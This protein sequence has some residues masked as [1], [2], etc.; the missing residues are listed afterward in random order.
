MITARRA[1]VQMPSRP[2]GPQIA[3]VTPREAWMLTNRVSPEG[4]NVAPANSSP[5]RS[6]SAVGC[7]ASW[8]RATSSSCAVR[9]ETAD[10]VS[11]G[12]SSQIRMAPR[13]L[14]DVMLSGQLEVGLGR[15]LVA[16]RQ[17]SSAGDR[18]TRPA[19]CRCRTRRATR[20]ARLGGAAALGRREVDLALRVRRALETGEARRSLRPTLVP[21]VPRRVVVA[22][23]GT[24]GPVGNVG[25]GSSMS[26]QSTGYD[27]PIFW[28]ASRCAR[29]SRHSEHL[30]SAAVEEAA[31]RHR[32]LAAGCIGRSPRGRR[33]CPR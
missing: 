29:G 32:V 3:N 8:F 6:C 24:P 33:S 9:V 31:G 18:T 23:R 10:V 4:L 5:N 20:R 28:P 13:S 17:P 21:D 25:L 7:A 22:R 1:D 16:A 26:T 12:P 27:A 11:T 14:R 19:R 2:Q 15:R 30:E